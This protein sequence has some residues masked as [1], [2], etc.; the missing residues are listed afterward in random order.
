MWVR[1]W[2]WWVVIHSPRLPKVT[3]CGSSHPLFSEATEVA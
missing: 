3:V 2:Q 1:G